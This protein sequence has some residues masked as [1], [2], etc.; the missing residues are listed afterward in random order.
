MFLSETYSAST[1]SDFETELLSH[2]RSARNQIK[3]LTRD[4]TKLSNRLLTVPEKDYNHLCLGVSTLTQ[5]L[6]AA[7]YLIV[8]H[9]NKYFS[10]L[11]CLRDASTCS[12]DPPD[13]FPKKEDQHVGIPCNS[14][15]IEPIKRNLARPKVYPPKKKRRHYRKNY[16]LRQFII[17][18]YARIL[19]LTLIF[20]GVTPHFCSTTTCTVI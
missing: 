17:S 6:L 7:K 3:K 19:T 16:H 9:F 20:L 1:L 2:H 18:T 4:L 12:R 14:L 5:Q 13:H 10:K 11:Q 15:E 8:S